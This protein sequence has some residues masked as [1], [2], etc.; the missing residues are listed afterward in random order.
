MRMVTHNSK[1]RQII[2][3]IDLLVDP[4]LLG[5]GPVAEL[6]GLE[7]E[8]DLMVGRLNSVGAMADVAADLIQALFQLKAV[9]PIYSRRQIKNVQH[10]QN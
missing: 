1:L 8:G 6:L 5:G 10:Q 9:E 2:E 7:P 4:V 3:K